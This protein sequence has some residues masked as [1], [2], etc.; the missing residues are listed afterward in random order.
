MGQ[1]FGDIGFLGAEQRVCGTVLRHAKRACFRWIPGA[2]KCFKGAGGPHRTPA[3]MAAFYAVPCASAA[4]RP[5]GSLLAWN[6]FL[7]EIGF[8]G[9]ERVCGTVLRHAKRNFFVRQRWLFDTP[10]PQQ[11]AGRRHLPK[12]CFGSGCARPVATLKGAG[13][14]H[15][16][17]AL[18]AGID[19]VAW[20]SAPR[21]HPGRKLLQLFAVSSGL[22]VVAHFPG[23]RGARAE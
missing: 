17:P 23:D 2:L 10:A 14:P 15:R 12:R 9:A 20:A 8:L 1:F 6:R 19:A 13:K 16:T 18:F 3:L 7:V 11:V 4:R 21:H 22:R 5:P